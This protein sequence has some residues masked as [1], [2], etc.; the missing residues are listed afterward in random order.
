MRNGLEGR[1]D[2]EKTCESIDW[3]LLGDGTGHTFLLDQARRSHDSNDTLA[4]QAYALS[5]PSFASA[6]PFFPSEPRSSDIASAVARCNRSASAG[7][8]SFVFFASSSSLSPRLN[9][10]CSATGSGLTACRGCHLLLFLLPGEGTRFD[11]SGEPLI[12]SGSPSWKETRGFAPDCGVAGVG[13]KRSGFAAGRVEETLGEAVGRQ[14]GYPDEAWPRTC[15]ILQMQRR[16]VV[17]Q[18]LRIRII[19]CMIPASPATR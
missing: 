17:A 1:R 19:P 13:L 2:H 12:S 9:G 15:L 5:A 8:G 11:G 14:L 7:L 4:W 3:V 10:S 18:H 16:E 6:P